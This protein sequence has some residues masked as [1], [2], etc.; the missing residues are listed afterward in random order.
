WG[1]R[2]A[3]PSASTSGPRC[4]RSSPGCPLQPGPATA[5]SWSGSKR[6]TTPRCAGSWKRWTAA[7]TKDAPVTRPAAAWSWPWPRSGHCE[8]T[9]PS[10]SRRSGD[11]GLRGGGG[12]GAYKKEGTRDMRR[13]WGIIGAAA[14]CLLVAACSNGSAGTSGTTSSSGQAYRFY[15]VTHGDN[16]TFWS[17][18]Q[19][20]EKQAASD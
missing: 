1:R 3:S 12:D 13:N 8:S 9:G 11:P 4:A 7:A 10:R 20:G 19:K 16:G 6:P 17:V 2:T 14:A 15:M 5:T 18:V